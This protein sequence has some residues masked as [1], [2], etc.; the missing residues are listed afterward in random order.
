MTDSQ[1]CIQLNKIMLIMDNDE[2]ILNLVYETLVLKGKANV[3]PC[4]K[5]SVDTCKAGT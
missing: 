1:E 3:Y 4:F 5:P 2:A